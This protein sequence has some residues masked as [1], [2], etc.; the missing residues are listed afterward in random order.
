[1]PT[2][3]QNGGVHVLSA[4]PTGINRLGSLGHLG[5]QGRPVSRGRPRELQEVLEVGLPGRLESPGS[6]RSQRSPGSP[7]QTGALGNPREDPSLG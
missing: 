3:L 1:M 4:D 7:E 6:Q 2:K 5:S